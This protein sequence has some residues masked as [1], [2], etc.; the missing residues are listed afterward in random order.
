MKYCAADYDLAILGGSIY[1]RLA[2]SSAAQKGA[3]VALIAPNWRENNT[4]W[5]LWQALH[6]A[7]GHSDRLTWPILIDWVSSRCEYTSLSPTV[8]RLQGIDVILE[9]G[10][11]RQDLQLQLTT[12]CLK[13]SRYLLTDGYGLS[14]G[15]NE[16]NLLCNQLMQLSTIPKRITIVGH[17]ATVVEWAYALSH[18]A[19]VTLTLL[20]QELLPA[21]DHD[22]QRLVKGQLKSL[23]IDVILSSHCA[24]HSSAQPNDT[25]LVVTVP[26]SSCWESLGLENIGLGSGKSIS[27]N[28]YLQTNRAQIYA[29]G[30]SLGGEDRAELTQQETIIAVDNALFGRRYIISYESVSYAIHLLSPIGRWGMTEEQAIARF[31]EAVEVF[32][33]S[34]LPEMTENPMQTNFC[35]FIILGSKLLGLHLMGEGAPTL[36]ASLGNRPTI[37]MLSQQIAANVAPGTLTYAIYQAIEQWQIARWQ[38][39]KWRRDWAENWFNFRRSM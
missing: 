35:K 26:D 38:E 34:C 23:G 14:A 37:E 25:D 24:S 15:V 9:P 36:V 18:F 20:D 19:T 17:G 1:S 6:M 13:A 8:L 39:G 21:E 27:V 29:S 32:Q 30:G 22:I 5:Y 31:G 2:A 3:R 10:S 11:F 12:R 16:N 28:R 4:A 7:N 33:A